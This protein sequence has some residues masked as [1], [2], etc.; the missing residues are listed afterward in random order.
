MEMRHQRGRD[1]QKRSVS[2]LVKE[3]QRRPAYGRLWAAWGT[4]CGAADGKGLHASLLVSEGPTVKISCHAAHTNFPILKSP[5]TLSKPVSVSMSQFGNIN[6]VFSA[7]QSCAQF[8]K[9]DV[10]KGTLVRDLQILR[11]ASVQNKLMGPC[12]EIA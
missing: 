3:K 7:V 8:R 10:P 1:R 4:H 6:L 9:V 11:V 5:V 12:C 2:C